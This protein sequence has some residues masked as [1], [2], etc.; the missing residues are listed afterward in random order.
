MWVCLGVSVVL[1]PCWAWA[2]ALPG[3]RPGGWRCWPVGPQVLPVPLVMLTLRVSYV[4]YCV[5][6]VGDDD[7]KGVARD[8]TQFLPSL[9]MPT[10]CVLPL[11]LLGKSLARVV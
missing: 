10:V 2:V 5:G 8:A 9:T 7:G 11:M 1:G 6:I 3:W 4:I